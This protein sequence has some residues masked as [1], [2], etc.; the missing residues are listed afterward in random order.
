MF[1]SYIFSREICPVFGKLALTDFYEP[2]IKSQDIKMISSL[3]TDHVPELVGAILVHSIMQ[4][5][6]DNRRLPQWHIITEL[7]GGSKVSYKYWVN[8]FLLLL[9]RLTAANRGVHERRSVL[10]ETCRLN[11]HAFHR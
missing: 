6:D 2:T 7:C 9:Y 11:V 4:N 3:F 5:M 1:D 10:L 8:I